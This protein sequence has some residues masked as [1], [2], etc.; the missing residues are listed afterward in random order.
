MYVASNLCRCHWDFDRR[1]RRNGGRSEDLSRQVLRRSCADRMCTGTGDPD[2]VLAQH[3]SVDTSN[4][5][6][7]RV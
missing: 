2:D 6:A 1:E 5:D 3:A 7:G 4:E